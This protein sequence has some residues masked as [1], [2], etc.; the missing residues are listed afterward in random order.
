MRDIELPAVGS[1]MAV[2]HDI[3]YVT[4]REPAGR[5]LA[6]DLQAGTIEKRWRVGHS[7]MAPTLSADGR[8]LCVANRFD[9]TVDLIDVATDQIRTVR[10]VREP[11]GLAFSGDGRRLFVANHLPEVR[12]FLD[13]ENPTIAAEVSVIDVDEGRLIRNIELPN[14]SQGLRG[15]AISP[16]GEY[17]VA[18]HILSHWL[19]PP[20]EIEKGAMNMNALSLID[21]ETLEWVETVILDDPN[22]G[23]ANPWAVAFAGDGRH[24][25]VT[26][27]GTHE[28]S[29][30]DWPALLQRVASRGGA[31]GLYDEDDLTMM[32]GIR[33]RIPLGVNGPRALL[34]R[35]GRVYVPGYYSSDLATV[36]LTEAEPAA[37]VVSLGESSQESPA[38]LGEQYFN[39]A[40]LC[41]QQWQSCATCHPDGRSDTLY[42][43]LL[44]DGVANTKNTKS[45]LMS[46]LTPPV[47][48]RGVRADAGVAVRAGIHHIQFVEPLPE[49]AEAID[50]WLLHMRAVPG[51]ALDAG[52]V[53]GPKTEE[54]NCMKCHYPGVPRGQLTAAA[55]RGKVLFEGRAGCAACHPHPTFTSME[56][57]DPGLGS[58]VRYDVPSLIEVWRTAPYLHSGDA[59][60][61]RETITDFN[62]MQKRGRT[63]DLT[64]RELEDLL[65]YL[66]SL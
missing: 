9:N 28:L 50:A 45:L 51:P 60:T 46:A 65:A 26:H 20:T 40:K 8:L 55:R 58:G 31:T 3:A 5:V 64:E 39:D 59:L 27:A 34:E 14:G 47:M 36:D 38:R 29:V 7:P 42:W 6:V 1:G 2:D 23:A 61:L 24:L 22:L 48:W 17:V 49:Q 54:A 62:W 43:D 16:D 57:V 15:I 56:K 33:R 30:I 52:A 53:E 66:R 18:T 4:T 12:P 35:D 10:V 11:V 21:A 63:K 13:D 41:F 37:H 32:A 19:V 44:N 25:L